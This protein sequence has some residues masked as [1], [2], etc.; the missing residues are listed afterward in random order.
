MPVCISHLHLCPCTAV[1]N[2]QLGPIGGDSTDD[3]L[4]L[5]TPESGSTPSLIPNLTPTLHPSMSVMQPQL[6]QEASKPP[7]IKWGVGISH[8]EKRDALPSS[9]PPQ[10]GIND[11]TGH[12]FN[13]QGSLSACS[14]SLINLKPPFGSAL[15][16]WSISLLGAIGIIQ[17]LFM[18][19]ALLDF[20]LHC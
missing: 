9:L 11:L 12:L 5:L 10:I 19:T 2:E 15:T 18:L 13:A 1:L 7:G 16:P 8:E 20:L 14:Y 17:K 4:L 3:D 6:L